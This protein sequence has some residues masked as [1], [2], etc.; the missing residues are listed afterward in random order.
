MIPKCANRSWGAEMR[1][2]IRLWCG[3]AFLALSVF[4]TSASGETKLR[5]AAGPF[6]GEQIVKVVCILENSE[7]KSWLPK[8]REFS[9]YWDRE[10]DVMV[11]TNPKTGST[12]RQWIEVKG[13]ENRDGSQYV[14]HFVPAQVS[15]EELFDHRFQTSLFS[16]RSDG[17]GVTAA[18]SIIYGKVKALTQTGTC[19]FVPQPEGTDQ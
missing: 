18:H 1:S 13:F 7:T 8:P 11:P 15:N 3:S 2:R 10:N 6:P 5:P 16:I 12:A 17:T 19:T 9:L 4:A 14:A